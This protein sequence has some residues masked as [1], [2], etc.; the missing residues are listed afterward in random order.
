MYADYY[1]AFHD[2]SMASHV[3]SQRHWIQ[4]KGRPMISH[5][6]GMYTYTQ[7]RADGRVKHRLHRDLP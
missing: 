1:K 5:H 2:G 6:I 7:L 4:D 3:E